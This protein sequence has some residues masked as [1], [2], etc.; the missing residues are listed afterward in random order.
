MRRM[1]CSPR[2]EPGERRSHVYG[3]VVLRQLRQEVDGLREVAEDESAAGRDPD[4]LA[5]PHGLRQLPADLDL[6]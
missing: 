3:E 2:I 5:A 4:E 6:R 1:T